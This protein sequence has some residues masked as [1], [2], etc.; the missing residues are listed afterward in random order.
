MR[1]T[2]GL[3]GLFLVLPAIVRSVGCWLLARNR[4]PVVHS[5]TA[6]P[7]FVVCGRASTLAAEASDP[8]GDALSYT[9][10][11]TGGTFPEGPTGFSVTWTAP[12]EP[13]EVTANV[14]VSDGQATA[15]GSTAI[16]VTVMESLIMPSRGA[17]CR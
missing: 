13:G 16:I 17:G 8:D 1:R 7:E 11:A 12:D 14:T 3:V 6:D 2:L 5:I 9:W 10:S 15:A 4:P